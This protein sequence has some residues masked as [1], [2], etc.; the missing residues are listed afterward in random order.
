MLSIL[1]ET[2]IDD[3]LTPLANA[4][5]ASHYH[6]ASRGIVSL[7]PSD[8]IDDWPD[9]HYCPVAL[10]L[11]NRRTGKLRKWVKKCKSWRCQED[12]APDKTL[13]VLKHAC[14]CFAQVQ[15][16]HWIVLGNDGRRTKDLIRQWRNRAGGASALWIDRG[17]VI[18][19]Y[20]NVDIAEGKLVQ[21][22]PNQDLSPHEAMAILDESALQLP[23]VRRVGWNATWKPASQPKSS[24]DWF[25]PLG[26][27]VSL[28][29]ANRLE[30]AVI[31]RIPFLG[32]T[33]IGAQRPQ[34]VVEFIRDWCRANTNVSW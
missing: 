12:C 21:P 14:L 32:Q 20:S 11:V 16:V 31:E 28:D 33:G 10:V 24:G 18:H 15:R 1:P 4:N 25:S 26:A 22:G 19:V 2:E 23:G 9:V 17:E 34:E 13:E 30:A 29:L 3:N 27:P 7:R 6:D 5:G 8:A